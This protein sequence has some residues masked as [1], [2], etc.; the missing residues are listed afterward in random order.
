MAFD[1]YVRTPEDLEAAIDEYGIVPFF[2]NSI[3]GF[4]ISEHV[5]PRV[6]FSEDDVGVW[7]WKGPVI[8]QCR[9]A[10]GK[11]FEKKAAFV[12]REMY[13]DLANWRRDGYDFDARFDDGLATWADKALFELVDANAPALSTYLKRLGNYRKGGRTGFDASITRLQAQGYV[14][15]DDFVY[16]VDRRGNTYGWGTAEYTT[17]EKF[18]GAEFTEKVYQRTPEES[19]QR[20][21]AHLAG[22]FPGE[23][24]SALHRFLRL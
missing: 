18:W 23:K 3:P 19:Y 2:K 13:L 7:E 4:S 24:E 14:L 17:P 21:L 12:S 10:Y 1:L 16:A 5:D 15:T 8:R 20:L 9:C 22:L 6:W 11:L